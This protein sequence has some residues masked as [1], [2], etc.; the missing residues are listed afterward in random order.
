MSLRLLL[1]LLLWQHTSCNRMSVVEAN[2]SLCTFAAE[3]GVALTRIATELLTR[4]TLLLIP[5]LTRVEV[6]RRCSSVKDFLSRLTYHHQST[7]HQGRAARLGTQEKS[8]LE[9]HC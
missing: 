3:L 5:R 2:Q 9:A 1:L 7:R 6:T 8:L 4:L